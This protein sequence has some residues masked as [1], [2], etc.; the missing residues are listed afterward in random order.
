[1]DEALTTPE[2]DLPFDDWGMPAGDVGHRFWADLLRHLERD[3]ETRGWDKPTQLFVV[4][5]PVHTLAA[6]EADGVDTDAFVAAMRAAVADERPPE[7]DAATDVVTTPYRIMRVATFNEH[8]HDALFGTKAPP[9]AAALVLLFEGWL[10]PDPSGSG[11]GV[12]PKDAPNRQEVRIG[13]V[14]TRT[15][16]VRSLTRVRGHEPQF[17]P[18]EGVLAGTVPGV[19]LRMLD[20]EVPP[21]PLQP[22]N[23]LA[24]QVIDEMAMAYERLS[25]TPLVD[26]ISDED[27][28]PLMMVTTAQRG[29]SWLWEVTNGGKRGYPTEVPLPLRKNLRRI[30]QGE[31]L[32]DL[33]E[34]VAVVADVTQDLT[35][36]DIAAS[37]AAVLLPERAKGSDGA[38]AGEGLVS[39]LVAASRG[40]DV[41]AAVEELAEKTNRATAE[42]IADV[43]VDFGWIDEDQ[44][45]EL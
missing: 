1:M 11:R 13:L 4:E 45:R 34:L 38:W 24:L 23:L 3:A 43:L 14:A 8:A 40:L 7:A 30:T 9:T 29:M 22:R 37:K 6:L 35:W 18:P 10:D 20:Q 15:G 27:W 42:A 36:A 2:A 5:P 31:G 39:M 41:W 19:L 21:C 25:Q 28:R 17:D 12:C 32:D 26:E 16:I 33:P 44:T